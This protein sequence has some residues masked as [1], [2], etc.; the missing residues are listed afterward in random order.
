MEDKVNDKFYEWLNKMC[1]GCGKLKS[2]HRKVHNCFG[3]TF[4]LS[5]GGGLNIHIVEYIDS[6]V[7]YFTTKLN[8]NDR[9]LEPATV[10]L[11]A[12]GKSDNLIK[13]NIMN[14][15]QLLQ[16][17]CLPSREKVLTYPLKF[18]YYVL[19]L[20]ILMRMNGRN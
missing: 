7:K 9:I 6:M 19:A 10:Y 1:G 16:K 4:Y 11:F 12:F 5:G 14:S 3:M 17:Y 20:K 15:T 2:K 18:H 8:P 13:T